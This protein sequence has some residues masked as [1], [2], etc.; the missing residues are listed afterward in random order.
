MAVIGESV[1][2]VVALMVRSE[3]GELFN[4]VNALEK[5][6]EHCKGAAEMKQ[7]SC[8]AFHEEISKHSAAITT[9]HEIATKTATIAETKAKMLK[10]TYLAASAVVCGFVMAAPWI[11][12]GTEYVVQHWKW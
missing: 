1:G 9:I 5:A 7:F 12:S 2:K 6:N 10:K 8:A 4:R 11:R 3:I